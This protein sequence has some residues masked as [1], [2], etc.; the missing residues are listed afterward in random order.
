MIRSFNNKEVFHH[1]KDGPCIKL[2]W[3]C[4]R[5][6][7]IFLKLVLDDQRNQRKKVVV[8]PFTQKVENLKQPECTAPRW[9]NKHS[10]VKNTDG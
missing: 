2:G 1:Y 6:R 4:R 8:F 3:L 5:K 10:T 9:T 7:Q